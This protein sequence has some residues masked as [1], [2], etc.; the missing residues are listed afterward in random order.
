MLVGIKERQKERVREEK[1]KKGGIKRGSK[2]TYI[3]W[4]RFLKDGVKKSG[5]EN[6]K[7]KG[8]RD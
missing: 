7:R 8:I 5:K 2:R 4:N 6:Y 3:Y 1:R